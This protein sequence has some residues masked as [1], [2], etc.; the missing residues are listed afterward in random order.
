MA[1]FVQ[2]VG[3]TTSSGGSGSGDRKEPCLGYGPIQV[4]SFS[5]LMPTQQRYAKAILLRIQKIAEEE[6]NREFK[7][8]KS[9]RSDH[10]RSWCPDPFD[11]SHR[12]ESHHSS[13]CQF[14]C[15]DPGWENYIHE[16][17]NRFP[18]NAFV[19]NGRR[20]MGKTTSLLALHHIV[21]KL[22]MGVSDIEEIIGRTT[23]SEKNI[24]NRE[25]RD[26]SYLLSNTA[27]LN[28]FLGCSLSPKLGTS[29]RSAHV[30]P[31]IFPDKRE[32]E[33]FHIIEDIFAL[34]E[35]KLCRMVHNSGDNMRQDPLNE[36][37]CG[38]HAQSSEACGEIGHWSG[39]SS[40]IR[41]KLAQCAGK[42]LR[43]FH[44]RVT[45]GW[46]FAHQMGHETLSRDCVD[47]DEYV[48]RRA[49]HSRISHTRV[50]AWRRFVNE[51]LSLF[52]S[53][54][55]LIFIDDA[56]ISQEL[57]SDLVH[58]IRM[59][60]SHPRIVLVLALDRDTLRDSLEIVKLNE[61]KPTLDVLFRVH[62]MSLY[63][64]TSGNALIQPTLEF[65]QKAQDY[66]RRSIHEV[67][68]SLD[69]VLAR[70]NQFNITDISKGDLQVIY[71]GKNIR[72][73]YES[74]KTFIKHLFPEAD[75]GLSSVK[76]K[77]ILKECLCTWMLLEERFNQ[78][79][80][81][82]NAREI[83]HLRCIL[84]NNVENL[85]VAILGLPMFDSLKGFEKYL[86]LDDFTVK[87]RS[88]GS[89]YESMLFHLDGVE[90][91][92]WKSSECWWQFLFLL[93]LFWS[94]RGVQTI[95]PVAGISNIHRSYL[96]PE[97]VDEGTKKR[98]SPKKPLALGI[99]KILKDDF[100]IPRNCIYFRDLA[101]IQPVRVMDVIEEYQI[102]MIGEWFIQFRVYTNNIDHDPKRF[103]ESSFLLRSWDKYDSWDWFMDPGQAE[104]NDDGI[105][106]LG[107][108]L[109]T[110]GPVIAGIYF[111]LWLIFFEAVHSINGTHLVFNDVTDIVEIAHNK[112]DPGYF[113]KMIK[114]FVSHGLNSN[115]TQNLFLLF[116]EWAQN[117]IRIVSGRKNVFNSVAKDALI[118]A[119]ID[120]NVVKIGVK[121]AIKAADDM[122]TEDKNGKNDLVRRKVLLAWALSPLIGDLLGGFSP[123]F[124]DDLNDWK[125]ILD[126]LGK[127]LEDASEFKNDY[128][129]YFPDFE[130]A[131]V[132]KIVI[133]AKNDIRGG[134]AKLSKLNKISDADKF[135]QLITLL[136]FGLLEVEYFVDEF[137]KWFNEQRKEVHINK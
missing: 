115:R 109:S 26:E 93:D 81:W 24:A 118:I 73:Y 105:R 83:I 80:V 123:L 136:R 4:H 62:D 43:F 33:E 131:I 23:E 14:C 128:R 60:L 55:L 100:V 27:A 65:L 88:T 114:L 2:G 51:Y 104:T 78:L 98:I 10:E 72:I 45:G 90:T 6:I 74:C 30:L 41:V 42:L 11:K 110:E 126:K 101:L 58:T 63:R 34:M 132:D 75:K 130:G 108:D 106:F 129:L 3:G 18:L 17:E 52:N 64:D 50:N 38:D 19:I 97:W 47:Y 84:E 89:L 79:F 113:D 37:K 112:N 85:T 69:K 102:F 135:K 49:E 29:R 32:L 107:R 82:A 28:I 91:I 124:P 20:G 120:E 94:I 133:A 92:I 125:D 99:S 31:V 44:S 96:F 39:S 13:D 66:V 137:K 35:D 54:L 36:F 56:D 86:G 77:N 40:D 59:Y 48:R 117:E 12:E 15:N 95:E 122:F 22:G 116:L 46:T 25:I 103:S 61:I 1:E 68:Q 16:Q 111:R 8:R 67:N 127:W 70:Q 134:K 9:P 21:A 71:K 53:E 7:E 5:E 76:L 57:C 119:G 87:L 121:E